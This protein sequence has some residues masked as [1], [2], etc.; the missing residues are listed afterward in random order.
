M[1]KDTEI[2]HIQIRLKKNE[3]D[4]FV[5]W[6]RNQ[7]NVSD[8]IRRLIRNHVERHGTEDI[9]SSSVQ[10]TMARDLLTLNGQVPVPV[11][12]T[13]V[14]FKEEVPKEEEEK[15][16]VPPVEEEISSE[17]PTKKKAAVEEHNASDW[18]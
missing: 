1:K 12:K 18:E 6:V 16:T 9:D 8:S 2:K 13:V 10:L 3:P 4:Y 11:P 15:E 14:E 17:K 5:D 7:E